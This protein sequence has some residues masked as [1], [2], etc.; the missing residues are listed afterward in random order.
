MAT[1]KLIGVNSDTSVCE[2]CG[3]SNLK[4]VAVIELENGQIVRY[5]R[6][7]AAMKLGKSMGKSIDSELFMIADRAKIS[8]FIAKWSDKYEPA[9]IIK[10]TIGRFAHVV[11][12]KNGQYIAA[13][14]FNK[15]TV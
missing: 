10:G 15:Y 13:T 5:G 9:Q 12:Y 14:G 1:A 7:C 2:C 11:E 4:S 6:D 3:K 8:A